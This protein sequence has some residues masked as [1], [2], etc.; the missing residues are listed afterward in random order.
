MGDG[1]WINGTQNPIYTY[2]VAGFYT[3]NLTTSNVYGSNTSYK[4]NVIYLTSDV[5]NNVKS[6]MHFNASPATPFYDEMGLVWTVSNAVITPTNYKFYNGSGDFTTNKA[7][8]YRLSYATL[9]LT[10]AD[11]T[12]EFW[13]DPITPSYGAPVITRTT[14][15]SYNDGWGLVNTNGTDNGYEFFMGNLSAGGA[16]SAF[17]IPTGTW[18]HVVIERLSGTIYIYING[19][20][21]TSKSGYNAN[22]DVYADNV[23]AGY[24]G[25][26]NNNHYNG[27]VDEERIS[28][29]VARWTSN[30]T[31][32]YAQYRGNT[33]ALPDI[34]PGS[35]FRFKTDP[36]PSPVAYVHNLTDTRIR[37]VQ[38][39]N[40]THADYIVGSITNDPI[41]TTIL[42]ITANTSTYSDISIVSSS[43]DNNVGAIQFNI[44]RPG[45]FSAP[46]ATRVS[47]IDWDQKYVNYSA[48]NT[49]Q[50]PYFTYGRLINTSI[51]TVYPVNIFIPTNLTY[52]N[53]NITS[54]FTAT[55]NKTTY[56]NTIQFV[57]TP[58]GATANIWNWS[59]GDGVWYNS[60]IYTDM[61]ASHT[62]PVIGNYTVNLTEGMWQNSSVKNTSTIYVNIT[63]YPPVANFTSNITY[64]LFPV[65]VQFNDT[66]SG[67][68]P[69]IWNWSFGDGTY[70]ST[71]TT[72]HVYTTGGNFTVN[73]TATNTGGSSSDY[74]YIT[75][76]NATVTGFNANITSG[77]APLPIAFTVTTPNDNAT[78]WNWSFGD[79]SYALTQ[80]VTH[81]YS[82]YGIYTVIENASN[83]YASSNTTKSNYVTVHNATPITSFNGFPTSGIQ[84]LVVTFTDT[85][86]VTGGLFWNWSY[87]DGT[88]GNFTVPTYPSHTYSSVGIYSV[89][90]TITNDG[91][92]NT[93]TSNNYITVNSA[94]PIAA[95]SE[96]VSTQGTYPMVVHF[97]DNSTNSPTQWNWSMGDGRWINGTQNPVYT[98]AVAGYYTVN[99]TA[100][101]SYGSNTL[102]KQNVIY[103]TSDVDN[104]VKSW[105]H[106]NAS[107][108]APFYDEMGLVWTI[109]GASISS[110]TYKF[111]TGS[112]LFGSGHNYIYRYGYATLNLTNQDFT[113]EMWVDP[114]SPSSGQAIVTRTTNSQ[115]YNDGWG[116]VNANGT[117]NGYTFFMG[118]LSAGGAVPYFTIQSNTW[119]HVVIERLSGTIYI[120]VNGELVSTKSGYN[121]NYDVY[122]DTV[123]IGYL[124]TAGAA[125]YNGNIDEFRISAGVARWT[126][127]FTTPY[128]EYIGN[129]TA[130][131]DI[132]PG[133]TL[134]YKT[135]PW[136]TAYVYNAT[137]QM[138]D[139]RNRTL[140]IENITHADF[141]TGSITTDP[142][143]TVINAVYPNR[144][145]YSDI[146]ITSYSIDNVTGE[147]LWN[148]TR[149]GGFSAP[150]NT[151]VSLI[152]F[153]Q[154]YVNYSANDTYQIP[155]FAFGYLGNTSMNIVFPIHY[156]TP[157]NLTYG[158][159][160][161]TSNFTATPNVTTK[162]ST[163]MFN[164]TPTGAYAN[165]WNWSFGDGTWYNSS[166]YLDMNASHTYLIIGNY[167]VNLTEGLWQNSSITNS[168]IVYVNIT[169][170][171]TVA[172]FTSNV[173][174]GVFPVAAQFN[175]TSSGGLP[176]IWNWSF[177]DGTYASTN[178]TSHVYTNGGNFTVNLTTTNAGGSTSILKYITVYNTTTSGFNANVTTG[179][180][181]LTVQFTDTSSNATTW[182]WMFGDGNTSTDKSPAF[183]Y[184]IIGTYPV[185]HS[186]SNAYYTSWTNET[187]YI[188]ITELAPVTDFNG[189][190]TSGI[191]PLTIQ[192][193]DNSTGGIPASWNWSFGDGTISSQQNPKHTYN[194]VGIYSVNLTTNN[195]GGSSS[196]IKS[197]YIT[198]NPM[199]AALSGTPTIGTAPLVVTFNGSSTGS[200]NTW[201]WNFGD[202]NIGIT[203]NL[204]HTYNLVGTYTVS[205][206]ATN[207]SSGAYSWD[208]QTAYITVTSPVYPPVASF[209]YFPISGVFPVTVAFTDTST[210]DPTSW[211]WDFGDGSSSSAENPSYVY[212]TGGTFTV[213]LTV[214]N[215]GGSSSAL[216]TISV[217]N[218]TSA[219]F[220]IS[221][222]SDYERVVVNFTDT[223]ANAT[224]WYWMFGD[225][226]T[227]T[228]KS[229]TFIYNI[230]GTYSVNHS[231]SNAYYTSWNNQSNLIT[232]YTNIPAADFTANAT[233]GLPPLAVHFID[234]STNTPTAW[235]WSFGDGTYSADKNPIHTYLNYGYYSIT[236]G[237]AN[238]YGSSSITKHNYIYVTPLTPT[239]TPT[240]TPTVT[241][242]LA[243]P[244]PVSNQTISISAEVGENY[245]QWKFE[246]TNKSQQMPPLDI[247]LDD[248]PIP[249]A[250]NFTGTTYLMSTNVLASERHDI[251]LYNSSAVSSN[252]SEFLAKATVK[253]LAPSYEIY[254]F[255]AL[256]IIMMVLILLLR[257][258]VWV[259]IIS[260][261]NIILSLF[262]ISIAQGHGSMPYIFIGIAIVSGILLL[263]FGLPKIR[264]EFDWL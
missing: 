157:T 201:Y 246:P 68:L 58:T 97:Y 116:F 63:D 96:N 146:S 74:K 220:T 12:I 187:G 84:P 237:V 156:F 219:T 194:S 38:I 124:G 173:T 35:T 235:N 225:G 61:N 228:D 172:N 248:S 89:S 130:I 26:G 175:D 13:A 69:T 205:L 122:A 85:S 148:V 54:N 133:S 206:Q 21:V 8:I 118:N 186:A 137:P 119:T 149:P 72:S 261:F 197:N 192:F 77:N 93:Y 41:Y 232:V 107:P 256:G 262:G 202:G 233:S 55:P 227:S 62:Y 193:T 42:G 51:N 153:N 250:R 166:N 73:L 145:S 53:W 208:N 90:E 109:R 251:I 162:Y 236:L 159:W 182:Y 209:S 59:F 111:P 253:S 171:P 200:P 23:Q 14:S 11:F 136:D 15:G 191:V 199:V 91:G 198:V 120:Y 6:W 218:K 169:D 244:S 9:N 170:I 4:H 112:G 31:T 254:F 37:T 36:A 152:D 86:T 71:N 100:S 226:N 242:T 103:L 163:V 257:E 142:L 123:N 40:V 211:Y 181:P 241:P 203:Q 188:N 24:L 243:P 27:L 121:A 239:P 151:N 20:L 255:I 76:Y 65:A 204:S 87:G 102:Y 264:E 185:N 231:A 83:A 158:E 5:D 221:N 140:E 190:P 141:I 245:I 138:N 167:T 29:G 229:P 43:I 189:T 249:A 64:G 214:S 106:F 75:V 66:S 3:V 10:N 161:I 259:V 22:Y 81:T 125:N 134:H 126:S 128:A 263:I 258:F 56:G 147:I 180:K 154:N 150:G 234:E 217:Y 45:G 139:G 183:I 28:A 17:T 114:T 78:A 94:A 39:Q 82:T 143:Y 216:H 104:N 223:G 16:T 110:S 34:N 2:A 224:S 7:N 222:A 18:T 99:L 92:S 210:G 105:M 30:F 25:P 177:G 47:I 48:N 113:I 79:G 252:G 164:S 168:S 196:L 155:Y 44:T 98:Y 101:N 129:T 160:N 70:A 32:P 135:A 176:T 60:S 80:N 179:I 260:T 195:T 184:N 115:N 212:T 33:N 215:V 19:Q 131:I 95:F 230:T 46:G 165:I 67:G 50:T 1:R 178:T 88:F 238:S 144:S 117:I 213:N 240:P 108:T 132:N 127:N 174:Y 207:T 52:G 49:Y 57:S 247:Y